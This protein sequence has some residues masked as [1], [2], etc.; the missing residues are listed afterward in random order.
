[1]I[2]LTDL[3]TI[4]SLL[5]YYNVSASKQLG[6]HFLI[7]REAL[8]DMVAAAEVGK[9]DYVVEI[10][11]GFGVLTFPLAEVAGRVLAIETDKRI[12]EILQALGS[13]LANLEVLPTSILKLS[14]GYLYEKFAAWAKV[15]GGKGHYKIVA[16]LPYYITSSIIKLLLEGEKKP[17]LICV[18]VQKEVAERITAAPGEMSVL[19]VSVQVYG[20]ASIVRY[21]SRKSFWPSPEV[22]SAI[23]KVIPYTKSPYEIDD[24]KGFFRIIKAGFGE[25]RKQLHNSLSGGLRLEPSEVDE[26][27]LACGIDPKERPQDL[28]IHQWVSLYNQLKVRL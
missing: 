17:E 7:D 6:Q 9:S 3:K 23:L 14:S 21:V 8:T 22:E 24:M 28:S 20:E 5:T 11:P 16:N 1:M 15:K 10:G 13:G 4:K 18:M 12:L 26:C 19:A 27:L 2:D 25:K